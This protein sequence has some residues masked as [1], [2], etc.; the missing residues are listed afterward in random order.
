MKKG[1]ILYHS[2]AI[3]LFLSLTVYLFNPIIFE[4]KIINQH[5]IEQWKGSSKE[6]KDYREKTG[7]EPLWT[8]SM[9]SGMPAYLIDIEWDNKLVLGIQKIISI[10]IPHPINH[11]FISLLSYYIML[12]IFNIRPVFSLIGSIFFSLSSYMII[13]IL[14]GHNARIGAIALMP[15]IVAGVHLGLTKNMKLGF[16]LTMISLALQIRINHLQITY[17]TL[18]ILIIYGI[19][20]LYYSYKEKKLKKDLKN[21][22]ILSLAAII[23]IGT[24]FGELWSIAEYSKYSIR[25]PSEIKKNESGLSKEYAFQY[26]NGIFEPLTLVIPNIFGGSSQEELNITS[27]LGQAFL[28][29]NISRQQ[30]REQLKKIPTYWGNQPFTAPYYVGALSL[31]FLVIGILLLTSKE[32]SWLLMLTALGI[33]LSWGNNFELFNSLLFEY[34]PGYNKFRSVTF[35]III[36]IFCIP[37]IGMLALEKLVITTKEISIS[38]LKKSMLYVCVFFGFMLIISNFL[39]Y[40]GTV[41]E[42]LKNL[43]NWFNSNLIADRKSMLIYDVLRS[44]FIFL[45]FSGSIYLFLRNKIKIISL[46]M[47]LLAIVILDMTLINKRFVKEESFMRKNK[48]SF[49]ISESDKII[50]ENNFNNQRVFNIQNTFNE[51]K[52]SYY[53]QSIGGY[54]GAKIRRYQDLIEHGISKEIQKIIKEIQNGSNDFSDYQLINMLNVG[55]LK[56]NTS[57]NGVIKNKYANGNAWYIKKIKKVKTPKEEIDETTTSDL[58]NIAVVDNIKFPNLKDEYDNQGNIIL[59]S[60]NSNH[61]IYKSYN[62]NNS[63]I[64][65]SEIFYPKGWSVKING[66]KSKLVRTNYV[67]RGL[68]VPPGENIIEMKFEPDPYVYGNLIT[69]VSSII[70]ILLIPGLLIIETKKLL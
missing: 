3:I 9:F 59:E 69:K 26:S 67:L 54:H 2:I 14:A 18:I 25:G 45:I 44:L 4:N 6:I 10:G 21:I 20:F 30:T 47:I 52:T 46:N 37:L 68:E 49:S 39:S 11:I 48:N 35:I 56:F 61:I 70:L 15:L 43:P 24:F 33:I 34:L 19:N 23:S 16:L 28:K 64:V 41:D 60:Y 36:T 53:H 57:A 51:A 58:K 50:L 17:Y 12:L 65:F 66:Q 40:T 55:Y 13:G 38:K 22:A 32:K 42:N 7:E 8:N 27:N 62:P 63:F 1:D 31:F 5:D 29:N